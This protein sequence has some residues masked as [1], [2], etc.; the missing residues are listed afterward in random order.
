MV[1]SLRVVPVELMVTLPYTSESVWVPGLL[2][3]VPSARC[4]MEA[5]SPRVMLLWGR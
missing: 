5:M 4:S 2:T 1:V 3:S